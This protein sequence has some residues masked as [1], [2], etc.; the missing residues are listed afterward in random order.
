MLAAIQQHTMTCDMLRNFN[1]PTLV[2]RGE[3]TQSYYLLINSAVAKCLP[4]AQEVVL[5]N[6]NHNGPVRD[7]AAFTASLLEF[8]SQR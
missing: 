1:R 7:P 5:K 8:L 4:N 3:K 2:M 6:V